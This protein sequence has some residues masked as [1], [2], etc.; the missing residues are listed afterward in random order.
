MTN[1]ISIQTKHYLAILAIVTIWG[2]NFVTMKIALQELTPFQLGAWRFV[3][4]LFPFIL[5]FKPP[6]IGWRWMFLNGT[7]QGVGQF[8]FLFVALSIGLS[9]SLA[10]MLLQTQVFFTA[11]YSFYILSE[12]PSKPFLIGLSFAGLGLC[13]FALNYVFPLNPVDVQ[14]PPLGIVLCLIGASMWG[15]S[16]ITIRKVTQK[17]QSFDSVNFIVWSSF[18]P[19]IPF[20]ILNTIFYPQTS[21]QSWFSLSIITWFA[22]AYLAVFSYL[23]AYTLWTKLIQTYGAN[24]ISPFSLGVPIIGLI[25]GMVILSETIS[26]WQW[27]GIIFCFIALLITIFGNNQQKPIKQ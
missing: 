15:A 21:I 14:I 26:I 6:Q 27:G 17:Y 11:L 13:C 4:S 19:I 20:V 9:A 22:I 7:F 25:S 8:G 12:K 18:M 5:F 24:R 10:S 3:F 1:K 16:N 2:T 23:I